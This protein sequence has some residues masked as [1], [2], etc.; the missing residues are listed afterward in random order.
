MNYGDKDGRNTHQNDG[1]SKG[2]TSGVKSKIE[3]FGGGS[4]DKSKCG[5]MAKKPG[6][7]IEGFSG[8]LM[9]G[10]IQ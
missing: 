8:G 6:A 3:G 1:E 2:S 9:D 7:P 4:P 10:K 5:D